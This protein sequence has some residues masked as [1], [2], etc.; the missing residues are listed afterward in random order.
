MRA[1]WTGL[2]FVVLLV[3][4]AC[5]PNG[6]SRDPD[7]DDPKAWAEQLRKHIARH[8]DDLAAQR[9]LALVQWLH[10]DQETEAVAAFDRL[11]AGDPVARLSRMLIA[12]ARLD[13]VTTNAH[14]YALVEQAAGAPAADPEQQWFMRAAAEIAARRIAVLH[15]E[16]DDDDGRFIAFYE[17]IALDRLSTSARQ[18]LVSVRA[19][20]ARTANQPYEEFYRRQGCVQSWEVAPMQGVRG[21]LELATVR[22]SWT[23]E[24]GAEA[25]KLACVVRVWNP[26]VHAGI[27]RMRTAL[28]VP[29]DV[30]ELEL[31]AE[32]AMRVW[33]DGKL[34]HRTDRTDRFP[35]GR[36]VLRIPVTPGVHELELATVV[37]RDRA[38]VLVRA[39]TPS[40]AEVKVEPGVKPDGRMTA[41]PTR[42]PS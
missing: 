36:T 19:N 6:R 1:A 14:A 17:R 18:A 40:G 30:L 37:P 2:A 26:T 39:T 20:L 7:G 3:L 41:A 24:P 12:D 11:A 13:T 28:R 32:E 38:W 15:G 23:P 5:R 8:P 27:R 35:R 22:P 16:L 4:S 10:L 31:S 21:E 25:V 33:L 9:D 29:G 42:E 34:V